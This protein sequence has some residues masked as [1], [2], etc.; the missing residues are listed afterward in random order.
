MGNYPANYGEN[1]D[2]GYVDYDDPNSYDYTSGNLQAYDQSG[3]YQGG[4]VNAQYGDYYD[5]FN[6]AA[7]PV[8]PPASSKSKFNRN[9]NKIKYCLI[10]LYLRPS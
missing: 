9:V 2:A 10:L 5:Q 6:P 4:Q 7:A 8:A 1:F 3:F